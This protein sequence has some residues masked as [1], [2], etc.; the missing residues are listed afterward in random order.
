MSIFTLW[1]ITVYLAKTKGAHWHLI[2]EIPAIF[3]TIVCLTYILTQKIG[4]GLPMWAG[5]GI[6]AAIALSLDFLLYVRVRRS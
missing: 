3:M 2:T 6:S 1:A 4:L 5:L